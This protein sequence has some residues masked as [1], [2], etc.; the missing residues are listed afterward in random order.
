MT[1][2][3]CVELIKSL[4][5]WWNEWL[6]KLSVPDL[7]TINPQ[8]HTH[9]KLKLFISI[10]LTT[11]RF[12]P[13]CNKSFGLQNNV[14]EDIDKWNAE[15]WA[16]TSHSGLAK[17]RGFSEFLKQHIVWLIDSICNYEV[18][19]TQWLNDKNDGSESQ[20]KAT[21][22]LGMM[23]MIAMINHRPH[24]FRWVPINPC[25][26]PFITFFPQHIIPLWLM[27]MVGII[28]Y[29]EEFQFFALL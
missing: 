6:Y 20:K 9:I 14:T 25:V 22:V 7:H 4:L 5:K 10:W 17:C 2:C 15:L 26:Q 3:V 21:L 23:V 12:I 16:M 19:G 13:K 27:L 8:W 24:L 1:R 11:T 18:W 28:E 29:D